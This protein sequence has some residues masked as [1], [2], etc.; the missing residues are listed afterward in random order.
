MRVRPALAGGACGPAPAAPRPSR[1]WTWA[2][3]AG[4]HHGQSEPGRSQGTAAHVALGATAHSGYLAQ[5]EQ[6]LD[7]I[8]PALERVLNLILRGKSVSNA[9]LTAMNS[10][11]EAA[12]ELTP[13]AIASSVATGEGSGEF[14]ANVTKLQNLL[15][16]GSADVCRRFHQLPKGAGAFIAW[17]ADLIKNADEAEAQEPWELVGGVPASLGKIREI[18]VRIRIIA[19]DAAGRTVHP[20]VSFA[21]LLGKAKPDNALRLVASVVETRMTVARNALAASIRSQLVD[22]GVEALVHVV[23]DPDA[24]LPW[25]P[26]K[27]LVVIPLTSQMEIE[28]HA[29]ATLAA[30]RAVPDG[31]RLTLIPSVDGLVLPARSVS[32]YETLLPLPDE[33]D[34]W[35][36]QLGLP[37]FRAEI[38]PI[39]NMAV[40]KASALQSMDRLNL[41]IAGRGRCP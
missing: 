33:A 3:L 5:A 4:G 31:I 16:A 23:E 38:S 6:L 1:R 39:L 29:I 32:G 20:G 7:R 22:N 10:V 19:G 28:S 9:Q 40:A 18:L 41:G 8:A 2:V 21:T 25:P 13:P 27:V 26:S 37:F 34:V 12:R 35:I 15:F 14:N 11:H 36:E 24:I 17:T 30:R